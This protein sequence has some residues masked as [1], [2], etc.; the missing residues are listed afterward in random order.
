M[1]VFVIG[2]VAP[3]RGGISHSGTHLCENLSK[4]HDVTAISFKRLYPKF[5]FKESMY[6][7]GAKEN[8]NFKTVT[9][10]DALNPLT[11]NETINFIKKEKPDRVI[12]QWWTTYLTICYLHIINGIKKHTKTGAV[13]Q[14][15]F[16]H[17][18]G[19]E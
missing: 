4:N 2:P 3:F 5:F 14:N 11:W 9:M 19:E 1:K 6:E 12:F 18:G 7:E 17:Q 15:V 13:L 10:L 16:P 8:P